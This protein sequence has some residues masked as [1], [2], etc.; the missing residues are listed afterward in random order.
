MGRLCLTWRKLSLRRMLELLSSSELIDLMLTT[1]DEKIII[2][3]IFKCSR[4]P[5]TDR[6][7]KEIVEEIVR[8]QAHRML[9]VYLIC[10]IMASLKSI[11]FEIIR[12]T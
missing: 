8:R 12:E 2:E 10:L 7:R 3:R 1:F 5:Y 4:M 6:E 11:L 9:K